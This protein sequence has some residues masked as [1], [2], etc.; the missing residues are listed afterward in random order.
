MIICGCQCQ[1][2][3]CFISRAPSASPVQF[4]ILAMLPLPLSAEKKRGKEHRE[5]EIIRSRLERFDFSGEISLWN[6]RHRS[7]IVREATQASVIYR[8]SSSSSDLLFSTE[9][10]TFCECSLEVLRDIS[11]AIR[12][13]F[14]TRVST[15]WLSCFSYR[16]WRL[17]HLL[18]RILNPFLREDLS[19][20]ALSSSA[21]AQV[22]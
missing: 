18:L 14:K 10:E 13:C 9:R 1:Q 3:S 17:C 16:C 22:E 11:K 15:R 5:S 6:R 21:V 20:A 7:R 8:S 4:L 19:F 12:P 2:P